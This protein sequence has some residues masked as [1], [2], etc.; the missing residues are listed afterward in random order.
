[1]NKRQ[2]KGGRDRTGNKNAGATARGQKPK[3]RSKKEERS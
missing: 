3:G 1:M 2:K